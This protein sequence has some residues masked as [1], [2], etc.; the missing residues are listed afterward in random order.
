[1]YRFAKRKNKKILTAAEWY[2]KT[3]L[4]LQIKQHL[5]LKTKDK[6]V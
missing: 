2:K 6:T 4:I 1:V 5:E 3:P